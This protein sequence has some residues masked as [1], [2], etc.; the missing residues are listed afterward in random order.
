MI[1][2]LTKGQHKSGAILEINPLGTVPFITIKGKV[3]TESQAIMR[4]LAM[5]YPTLNKYYP[6]LTPENKAH[7][8]I[9]L[10]FCCTSLRPTSSSTVVPI[11]LARMSGKEPTAEMYQKA[12]ESEEALK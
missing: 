1:L 9:G 6:N 5:T 4:Y 8:D 11:V 10:D 7:I 2:D 12:K 3:H